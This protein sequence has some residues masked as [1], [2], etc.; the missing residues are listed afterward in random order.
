MEFALGDITMGKMRG[1]S[2]PFERKRPFKM[3][4]APSRSNG[5]VLSRWRP[6]T[7]SEQMKKGR[8]LEG[9]GFVGLYHC[10]TDRVM[11]TGSLVAF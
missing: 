2:L 9:I 6:L 11:L 4:A 8:G 5:N 7:L 10:P 3:A 1:R